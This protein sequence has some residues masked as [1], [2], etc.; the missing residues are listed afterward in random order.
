MGNNLLNCTTARSVSRPTIDTQMCVFEGE[1]AHYWNL[2]AMG[3]QHNILLNLFGIPD[4]VISE[5]IS[6]S[7]AGLYY[8]DGSTKRR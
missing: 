2:I 5:N 3:T 4:C 8:R 7:E 1:D 6:Q